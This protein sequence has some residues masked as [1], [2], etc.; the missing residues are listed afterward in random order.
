MKTKR[1]PK[2]NPLIHRRFSQHSGVKQQAPDLLLTREICRHCDDFFRD[3]G[4]PVHHRDG[5][6]L[7]GVRLEAGR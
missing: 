3:R 1:P 6:F 4:M 2:L 5:L 7:Y